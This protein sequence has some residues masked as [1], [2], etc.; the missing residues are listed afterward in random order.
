MKVRFL[1]PVE[2]VTGSCTWLRDDTRDIEFLI[3]CGMMQGEH[4]HEDGGNGGVGCAHGKESDLHYAVSHQRQS[5][6]GSASAS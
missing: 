1:N 5:A 3:D 6:R 4:G 2:Q